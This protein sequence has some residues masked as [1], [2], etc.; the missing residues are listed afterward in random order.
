MAL[1]SGRYYAQDGV[2]YV[3]TRGTVNAV[4]HPLAELAGI[5][6]EVV[7]F[8]EEKTPGGV[9]YST[10]C[11]FVHPN[12]VPKKN[13]KFGLYFNGDPSES[14]TPDTMIKSHVLYLLS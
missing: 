13:K 5:Y 4:F 6:V 2:T 12:I 1:E 14:R 8:H 7:C 9:Y 3:C 11:S 10:R